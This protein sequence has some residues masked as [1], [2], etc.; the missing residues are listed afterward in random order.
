MKLLFTVERVKEGES[1]PGQSNCRFSRQAALFLLL[2]FWPPSNLWT[3]LTL[4]LQS[5]EEVRFFPHGCFSVPQ[6]CLLGF[7]NER[8]CHG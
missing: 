6:L 8:L 4:H 7:G 3:L 5:L 1:A 2:C